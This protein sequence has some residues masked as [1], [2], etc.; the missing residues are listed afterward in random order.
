[1]KQK[2]MI[3]LIALATIPLL[4]LGLLAYHYAEKGIY[5]EVTEKL[6]SQADS[7]K[8]LITQNLCDAKETNKTA[9]QNSEMIVKQ[10]AQLVSK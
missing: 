8:D 2:I 7:D 1:M 10:Q 3:S 6:Q 4:V 9:E 5:T